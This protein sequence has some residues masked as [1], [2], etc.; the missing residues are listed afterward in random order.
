MAFEVKS[1][2]KED[3]GEAMDEILEHYKLIGKFDKICSI[4]HTETKDGEH[5]FSVHLNDDLVASS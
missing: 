5:F 1:S 3:R 4:Q 2:T